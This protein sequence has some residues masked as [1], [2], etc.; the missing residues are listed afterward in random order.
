[1]A[2]LEIAE[3]R[4]AVRNCARKKYPVSA[5]LSD[6]RAA[7]IGR[8]GPRRMVTAPATTKPAW[9][10][11]VRPLVESEDAAEVEPDVVGITSSNERGQSVARRVS[12]DKRTRNE[13]VLV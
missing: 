11:A 4:I 7:S 13:V 10:N 6:Q 8:M 1:I 12:G 3:P 9:T 2:K 5:S